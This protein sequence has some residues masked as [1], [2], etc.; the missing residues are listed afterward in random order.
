M[1]VEA[2][3]DVTEAVRWWREALGPGVPVVLVTELRRA[4]KQL[5]ATPWAGVSVTKSPDGRRRKLSLL[6]SRYL[7]FYEVD[8]AT[9]EVWVLRVW[10]MSRG[11]KPKLMVTRPTR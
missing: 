10:H 7:L 11:R 4:R 8:D 1:S 5:A 9:Q 3:E 2:V 6:E